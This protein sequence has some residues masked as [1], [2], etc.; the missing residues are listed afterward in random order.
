MTELTDKINLVYSIKHHLI[1]NY[2]VCILDD[3]EGPVSINI[4][5][6]K[7]I[8]FQCTERI[9]PADTDAFD[10]AKKITGDHPIDEIDPMTFCQKFKSDITHFAFYRIEKDENGIN[11]R[12]AGIDAK[13]FK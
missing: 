1:D 6:D 13:R 12:Y 9:F 5:D 10:I 7:K 11:I 3:M 8:P 4:I 2:K